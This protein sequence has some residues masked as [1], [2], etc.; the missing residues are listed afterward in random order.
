[1]G[2]GTLIKFSGA[3]ILVKYRKRNKNR[4]SG[5]KIQPGEGVQKLKQVVFWHKK[6]EKFRTR[7]PIFFIKNF[8]THQ[9][10]RKGTFAL[11]DTFPME[12]IV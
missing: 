8:S 4:A 3:K 6:C 12:T 5:P 9:C 11:K 7:H 10:C 2:G 1:M